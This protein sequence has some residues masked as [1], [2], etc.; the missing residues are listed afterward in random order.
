MLICHEMIIGSK[1]MFLPVTIIVIIINFMLYT[2]FI[3]NISVICYFKV[4]YIFTSRTN[5]LGSYNLCCVIIIDLY[6][7]I[8]SFCL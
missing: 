6:I 7:F 8:L 4:M 2:Y 1:K 3:Y 5:L